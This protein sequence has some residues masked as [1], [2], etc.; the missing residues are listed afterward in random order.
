MIL[1]RECRA[2]CRGFRG[3]PR[4]WYCHDCRAE[5]RKNAKAHYMERKRAGHTRPLGSI[6][7]CANCGNEYIVNA[8]HQRYC[9][10]CGPAMSAEH[11][12]VHGLE[13][14]H[15][16]KERINPVRNERRRVGF[17]S[18]KE[19]G[20]EFDPKHTCAVY[21]SPEC[22]RKRYNRIWMERYYPKRLKDTANRGK[23]GR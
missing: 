16:N 7:K 1:D 6:D 19:C 4:A 18:C 12:R 22:K 21:C 11:D 13:Y 9:P 2:C 10:E 23:G 14:Y 17:V 5:R 3:G 20:K 15:D 8:S